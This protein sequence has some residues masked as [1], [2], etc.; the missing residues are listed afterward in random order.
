[1]NLQIKAIIFDWGRTLFDS[2][3]KKEFS[4]SEEVV[5]F[6]AKRGLKLAV[7]SLVS[8]HSIVGLEGRMKQIENSPLRKYFYYALVT[9]KDKDKILSELVEKLG[10][11]SEKI[12]IV[13]DRVV[14]GIKYGNKNGHPTVWLQRGKFENELPNDETGLP[15]FTIKTLPELKEILVQ[16]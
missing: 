1:M 2:E 10:F 8:E 3:L 11:Q 7:A 6:C 13:D 12:L 15:T 9:D 4:E 14:R 16:I 5:S